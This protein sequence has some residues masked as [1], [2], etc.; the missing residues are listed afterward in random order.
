MKR[1]NP[2]LPTNTLLVITRDYSVSTPVSVTIRE[3]GTYKSETITV[4]PTYTENYCQL[5]CD[6]TILEEGSIYFM[7]VKDGSDL[8]YRD[9][10]YASSSSDYTPSL[11]SGEYTID[12]E[13]EDQEYVILD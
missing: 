9:K 2:S 4:T 10:L 8:L 12:T 1:V 11:N 7:E 13:G 3:D 6:F 5:D